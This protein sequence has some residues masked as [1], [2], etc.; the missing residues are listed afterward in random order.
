MPAI[1]SVACLRPDRSSTIA[2]DSKEWP[3]LICIKLAHTAIWFFFVACIVAIPVTAI[4]RRFRWAAGLTALV[5]V[6]CVV[7][8]ANRFRCPL[9]DLA[10][11]YTSDRAANFD[12][13]LPLWLAANNQSIFGTLFFASALFALWQWLSS[14]R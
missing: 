7:L 11:H 5:L 12:I 10:A 2:T 9:T 13:Y 3:I 6:E 4:R 8:A 1:Q 14:R